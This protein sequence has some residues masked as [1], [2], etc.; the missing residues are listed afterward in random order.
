MAVGREGELAQL[1]K[2]GHAALES[3]IALDDPFLLQW[4]PSS[5]HGGTEVVLPRDG[6]VQAVGPGQEGDGAMAEGGEMTNG[7][8]NAGGVVEQDGAGLGIV[9][10]ELG[11]HDGDAAVHELVEHGFLFAEGHHGDAVDLALQHAADASGQHRRV[12]VGGADQNLVAVSDGD[13]FKALDQLGEKRIGDVLDD[14]PEQAAAAGDQGA[15]VGVGKVIE[16]LDG[17]PDAL[18]ETFA[19]QRRTID[20]SGDCGDGNLCQGGNGA[21]VGQSCR[22]SCGLFCEARTNPNETDQV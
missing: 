9:Q 5:L 13:L 7:S 1:F 22:R 2:A 15:R 16:L 6:R 17:L 21:N 10:F 14:D 3:V 20:G 8:M 19:D 12:A 11:Q 4:Q 18:G